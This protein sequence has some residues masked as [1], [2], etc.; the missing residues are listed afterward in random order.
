MAGKQH[1][2]NTVRRAKLK[3]VDKLRGLLLG[4][5][6]G[7]LPFNLVRSVTE[8]SAQPWFSSHLKEMT[9]L[10]KA[11]AITYDFS[12]HFPA[13]FSRSKAFDAKQ[14]VELTQVNVSPLSGL[15]WLD[16]GRILQ[17]S[18]GSVGRIMKW[19][20]FTHEL[21]GP[22]KASLKGKTLI[23]CPDTGYFHFILEVL[24]NVLHALKKYPKAQL[25]L[26]PDSGDYVWAALKITAQ[27]EKEDLVVATNPVRVDH[28]VFA[29]FS[30]YSGYVPPEDI[31]VLQEKVPGVSSQETEPKSYYISRK[32]TPK[33]SLLGEAELEEALK[34]L[35]FEVVYLEKLSLR[36]QIDLLANAKLV[37]GPHGAGLSNLVWMQEPGKVLEIFPADL[38]NDCFARLSLTL[39][40][41]Y[42]FV[43]CDTEAGRSRIPVEKVVKQLQENWL[44]EEV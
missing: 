19:G 4:K 26:H 29:T 5:L 9:P 44:K 17:E 27:L 10:G 13:F 42:D 16:N 34:A 23:P 11:H 7:N 39:G 32:L 20:G 14:V 37:V 2:G 40:H 21:L 24:P 3:L 33:R 12:D 36:E 28:L 15:V 30:N 6:A 18:A 38:Y 22:V 25:L 35:G 31:R 41:E 43:R 8:V 1:K